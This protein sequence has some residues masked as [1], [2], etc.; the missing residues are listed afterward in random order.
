MKNRVKLLSRAGALIAGLLTAGGAY[1]QAT[2]GVTDT[3]I[4]IGLFAA[5]SGPFAGNGIDALD[6]ARAWY[7]D[8]NAKGGINGR[9]INLIVEDD[10]CDP[11]EA[12]NIARKLE[13]QVFLLN[14]GSCSGSTVSLQ[15]FVTREKIPHVFLNAAGDVGTLPPTRTSSVPSPARDA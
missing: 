1:A 9:K 3:T 7:E 15:E 14:G 11:T 12:N 4:T 8:T 5:L 10:K 13:D 2:P 6:A